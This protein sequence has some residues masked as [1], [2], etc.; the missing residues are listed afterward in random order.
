MAAVPP[1]SEEARKLVHVAFGAAA[2]LL[3]Y[4]EWWQ[5]AILLGLAVLFNIVLLQYVMGG[6]LHRPLER[7]RPL[8]AGLVLYP[9]SLLVLVL[10]FPARPDIVAACWGILAVGDGAATLAGRRLGGRRWPWNP[11]KSVAGSVA[12][13][14]AGGLAGSFLAWWCRPAVVPLPPLVFSVGAPWAAAAAAAAVESA[15]VRLNDNLT[16]PLTAA[17][18]LFLIALL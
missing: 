18:V 1:H 12:L 5:T 7:G 2:L 3:R 11:E 6:R 9:A 15:P 17:A 10:I 13:L 8:A 14:V 16:V 4:L